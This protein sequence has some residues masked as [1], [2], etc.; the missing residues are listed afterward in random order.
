M[1]QDV[2]AASQ[3]LFLILD[4][5]L[6]DIA[7][8]PGSIFIPDDLARLSHSAWRGTELLA[9]GCV[10][11]LCQARVVGLDS[12]GQARHFCCFVCGRA[13]RAGSGRGLSQPGA[14]GGEEVSE[15]V[16]GGERELDAAHAHRHLRADLE[17]LQTDASAGR[18]RQF[19]SGKRD[20]AQRAHEDIGIGGE[21]Q[22]QLVGAHGRG[23]RA[24]GIEI[25]LHSTRFSTSPRAQ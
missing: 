25:E 10:E 8:T 2:N 1:L 7:P 14:G 24:I 15:R 19:G 5:T 21:P 22:A 6:I 9:D 3:A 13:D 23:R 11:H 17:Q 4:G 12:G 16:G 18:F 20:A